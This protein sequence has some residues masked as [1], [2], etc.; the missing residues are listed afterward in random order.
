MFIAG[1]RCFFGEDSFAV[2]VFWS[3]GELFSALL[4]ALAWSAVVFAVTQ[5]T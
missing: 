5:K 2:S 3:S 1:G 4:V